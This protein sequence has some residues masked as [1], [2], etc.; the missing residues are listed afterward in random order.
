MDSEVDSIHELT[1]KYLKSWKT[2]AHQFI[3]LIPE[4]VCLLDGEGL[5]CHANSA[6]FSSIGPRKYFLMNIDNL[7]FLSNIMPF[8]LYGS[9]SYEK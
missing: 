8:I 6:F 9:W 5:I 3:E 2:E 1:G 4:A 7:S